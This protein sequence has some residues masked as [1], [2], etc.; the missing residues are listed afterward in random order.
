MFTTEKAALDGRPKS[1]PPNINRLCSEES[2][3]GIGL[4]GVRD[5]AREQAQCDSQLQFSEDLGSKK[6]RFQPSRATKAAAKSVIPQ[7]ALEKAHYGTTP[8]DIDG[9]STSTGHLSKDFPEYSSSSEESA[10]EFTPKRRAHAIVSENRPMLANR[11]G[12]KYDD[13]NA[14]QTHGA[15]ESENRQSAFARLVLQEPANQ[16]SLAEAASNLT[17]QVPNA[18]VNQSTRVDGRGSTPTTSEVEQ[19][20][21]HHMDVDGE[22]APMGYISDDSSEL[23]SVDSIDESEPP[24]TTEAAAQKLVFVKGEPLSPG[25]EE[26]TSQQGVDA[27]AEEPSAKAATSSELRVQKAKPTIS[28]RINSGTPVELMPGMDSMVFTSGPPAPNVPSLT[29]EM[30]KARA[31]REPL[32]PKRPLPRVYDGP[33]PQQVLTAMLNETSAGPNTTDHRTGGRLESQPALQEPGARSEVRNPPEVSSVSHT[34]PVHPRPLE[35]VS[36]NHGPR[37]PPKHRV[38]PDVPRSSAIRCSM[39]ARTSHV[40]SEFTYLRFRHLT[41]SS[42]ADLAEF[43]HTIRTHAACI[44][45]DFLDCVKR[46]LTKKDVLRRLEQ[47]SDY[48][49]LILN[50]AT[51]PNTAIALHHALVHA[52]RILDGE[53]GTV[54]RLAGQ[55]HNLDDD[56]STIHPRPAG[57]NQDTMTSGKR[58]GIEAQLAASHKFFGIQDRLMTALKATAISNKTENG[59]SPHAGLKEHTSAD[60]SLNTLRQTS[61]TE[62][63]ASQDTGADRDK[64]RVS[65]KVTEQ[66]TLNRNLGA[67]PQT[68]RPKAPTTAVDENP[69]PTHAEATR[70]THS[71][72]PA[73]LNSAEAYTAEMK[74]RLLK[75]QRSER[76][77]PR[78]DRCKDRDLE[79]RAYAEGCHRCFE[80]NKPH[81][82][83]CTWNNVNEEEICWLNATVLN[84]NQERSEPEASNTTPQN[85]TSSGVQLGNNGQN[86]Q[87]DTVDPPPAAK[88]EHPN[89]AARS[90]GPNVLANSQAYTAE[91]KSRVLR[92]KHFERLPLRC[93]R[94]R[95]KGLECIAFAA[96]CF[97][98]NRSNR[99]CTW[100]DLNEEEILWLNDTVEEVEV[101]K[102][103]IVLD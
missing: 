39:G 9:A 32:L 95:K 54:Q 90:A 58:P 70:D 72:A 28:T 73:A 56:F 64:A 1:I 16:G 11:K 63:R 78:C 4:D 85:A 49:A 89:S 98:C 43:I 99:T 59:P 51:A 13:D 100:N 6:R 8:M 41:T 82:R 35:A 21:T 91:M 87:T 83:Y 27:V 20:E 103:V 2:N 48:R 31:Q 12:M 74:S 3:P 18:A 77:Y 94:C 44:H 55:V 61:R 75:M 5:A 67:T 15:R 17:I 37:E 66:G 62:P 34:V 57:A 47:R 36:T 60:L 29:E 68:L 84:R 76:I 93:D 23:S 92:L 30:A 88:E 97:D 80:C 19:D 45:E 42:D 33:L 10:D 24:T 65:D 14:S 102:D 50:K 52:L 46:Y 69:I 71:E 40:H 86:P 79:C 25:P 26:S 7:Q 96:R 81:S 38:L 53:R 101:L 22:P